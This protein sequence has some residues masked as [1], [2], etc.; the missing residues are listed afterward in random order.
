MTYLLS[1]D[2]NSL[3]LLE[4]GSSSW[5]GVGKTVEV[6]NSLFEPL[7]ARLE[8]ELLFDI[9][10]MMGDESSKAHISEA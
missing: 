3:N 7:A 1:N 10:K 9:I 5:A 4:I 2:S 6:A 8:D